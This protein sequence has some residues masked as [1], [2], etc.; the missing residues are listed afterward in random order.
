MKR[1]A[2]RP[3]PEMLPPGRN[4]FTLIELLVVIAIIAILAAMLLPALSKAKTRAQA[5]SC[6]SNVRQINMASIMFSGDNNDQISSYEGGGGFWGEPSPGTMNTA[7]NG[8]G[9]TKFAMDYVLNQIQTND[10]LYPFSPNTSV[11]HCPGDQRQNN[12]LGNGWAYDSYARL[13]N[14]GGDPQN[15]YWGAGN[16]CHKYSDVRMPTDTLTF[17]ENAD[18]HPVNNGP[19]YVFWINGNPDSF[20]WFFPPAQFHVNLSNVGYSDGHTERHK[21]T[22]IRII[23]AGQSLAKGQNVGVFTGPTS[24]PDYDFIRNGYR[25]PGWQ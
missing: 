5:T 18:W 15:N 2:L 9:L 24:G 11:M 19:F 21:W 25:F 6:M 17:I 13:E 4:G 14:F 23:N 3:K 12:T 20:R 1:I 22:D 10:V 8:A 16:T 7:I